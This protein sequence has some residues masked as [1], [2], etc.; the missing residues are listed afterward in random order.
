MADD[1]KGKAGGGKA[2]AKEKKT[3]KGSC[4]TMDGGAIGRSRKQCPKCGS[5]V[6]LASH[7]DRDS[8]GRCGF[9]EWKPKA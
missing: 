5:G 6:F 4:Y 9:T 1:A 2:K 3:G 7:K 8:C